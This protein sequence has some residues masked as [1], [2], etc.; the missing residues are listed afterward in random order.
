MDALLYS[1]LHLYRNITF[2]TD[3]LFMLYIT[4]LIINNI[5]NRGIKL[6][7]SNEYSLKDITIIVPIKNEKRENVEQ[8]LNTLGKKVKLIFVGESAFPIKGLVKVKAGKKEKMI[9][10]AN[11]VNTP[12]VG[13]LDS[14]SI[15]SI[16]SIKR[17]ITYFSRG[18]GGVSGVVLPKKSNKPSYY[19]SKL[20]Y[21]L[22]DFINR[23]VAPIHKAPILNGNFAVYRTNLVREALKSI[24]NRNIGDD[25][26]LPN[27]LIKHG[28]KAVYARDISIY[29][30]TPDNWRRF[31]WQVIRWNQAALMN[32][33]DSIK[34]KIIHKRGISFVSAV[35]IS[36]ALMI[37]GPLSIL[38]SFSRDFIIFYIYLLRHGYVDLRA[39]FLIMFIHKHTIW[40]GYVASIVWATAL[41]LLIIRNIPLKKVH[42]ASIALAVQAVSPYLA[43]LY[44]GKDIWKR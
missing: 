9:I 6:E 36:L 19:Y 30:D 41:A 23:G 34:G 7:R 32:Y 37:L 39:L 3:F 25:K 14:D 44:L 1:I 42:I 13:F 16:S 24:S 26:E 33:I 10:G 38:L 12:L 28:Y 2:L 17:A 11:I 4:I 40:I 29:T 43:I 21:K 15:V 8:I 22:S 31:L 5:R 27:Y 20:Y 18:V 35:I